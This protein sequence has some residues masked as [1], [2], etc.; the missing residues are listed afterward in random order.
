MT[1]TD[2]RIRDALSADDEAFLDSLDKDRGLFAQIHETFRGPMRWLTIVANVLVIAATAAGIWAIVKILGAD[3][4]RA[5]ILW[6]AF[7]WAAWTIQIALKQWLWDRIN[8][9]GILRELKRIELRIARL[10]E[11]GQA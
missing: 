10:E 9:L 11:G 5:L 8:T 6:A 2:R 7:G 4:T 1:D 3:D